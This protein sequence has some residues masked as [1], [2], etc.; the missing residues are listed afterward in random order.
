MPLNDNNW[1]IRQKFFMY[2]GQS[3]GK[4]KAY[5]GREKE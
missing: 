3:G 5:K 4:K 1:S 2:F